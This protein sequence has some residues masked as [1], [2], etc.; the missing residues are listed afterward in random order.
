MRPNLSLSLLTTALLIAATPASALDARS[1]AL[2]G[3]AIAAGAGVHGTLENPATLMRLQR[4]G[5]RIHLRFGASLD[6]RD[7]GELI[8][9]ATDE[10]NEDLIESIE[11]GIANLDNQVA[12]P[13]CG[14]LLVADAITGNAI[15]SSNENTVC[16]DDT[17][18]LGSD[19]ARVL[20]ILNLI[21][22]ETIDARATTD[23]GF[24]M[25][26]S[27]VPFAIHLQASVTGFGKPEV[28]EDDRNYVGTFADV[29]EDSQV[30]VGEIDANVLNVVGDA[31]AVQQPEDALTSEIKA[32]ILVRQQFGLSFATTLPVAGIDVDFGITPKF[33]KLRA[34][35]DDL[36]VADVFDETA[37]D[38][39]DQFEDSE[40]S[41]SSFTMDLGAS[42]SVNDLPLR[43][44]AVLR[45]LIPESIATENG[46]EFETTPQLIIGGVYDLGVVS[47]NA[48][49][50]LNSAKVDNFET[51]PIALG[52]EFGT[53]LLAIRGGISMDAAREDDPT[54]LSLGFGLGP[55]QVGAR[56][57]GLNAAQASAQLSFSF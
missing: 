40:V 31:L 33:S 9:I 51:Q 35:N 25:T 6:V 5:Q 38:L 13:V 42:A 29:L 57:A 17:G 37:E 46:F 2:G 53:R 16:V 14:Q 19:A 49:L 27:S 54:A 55:L 28:S 36:S 7:S 21:D 30:V 20:D 22:G 41:A 43:V 3:S 26:S 34:F 52:I 48:D 4:D 18:A 10:S 47:I 24:A 39:A 12:N 11:D 56:V 15:D 32:S 44:A 8:D 23:L 1:T 45:N 50:A